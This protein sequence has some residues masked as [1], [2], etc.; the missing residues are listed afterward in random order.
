MLTTLKV[1]FPGPG[2]IHGAVALRV[3]DQESKRGGEPV[4]RRRTGALIDFLEW[5]V[6]PVAALFLTAGSRDRAGT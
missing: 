5:P 1:P 6:I 2:K 3:S 4:P